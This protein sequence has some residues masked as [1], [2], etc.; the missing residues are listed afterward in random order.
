MLRCRRH[1]QPICGSRRHLGMEL[2]VLCPRCECY[3]V[4]AITR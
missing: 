1:V 4:V 2:L 3:E